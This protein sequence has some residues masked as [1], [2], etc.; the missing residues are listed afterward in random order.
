[1]SRHGRMRQHIKEEKR[2]E[3]PP[4]FSLFFPFFQ[5][6]ALL[7]FKWLAQFLSQ[8]I[9]K[10][11]PGFS[12]IIWRLLIRPFS[13]LRYDINFDG[14]LTLKSDGIH[15]LNH[16]WKIWGV[17]YFL[18]FLVA[19]KDYRSILLVILNVRTQQA[20]WLDNDSFKCRS[21]LSNLWQSP[22]LSYSSCE[23]L[24]CQ[25]FSKNRWLVNNQGLLIGLC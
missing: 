5:Q 10:I 23:S 19:G 3:K 24:F 1:M 15:E 12:F 14:V 7:I 16:D 6:A 25:F 4:W 13:A 2:K 9:W 20:V 18:T 17:D 21:T 22:C 8:K 11:E